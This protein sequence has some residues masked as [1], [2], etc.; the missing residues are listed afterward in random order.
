MNIS[1]IV[2]YYVEER[3]SLSTQQVDHYSFLIQTEL[4]VLWLPFYRAGGTLDALTHELEALN[5]RSCDKPGN[6]W[7]LA[8]EWIQ[9]LPQEHLW[10]Q[11]P[12]VRDF[13]QGLVDHFEHSLLLEK[14]IQKFG[15]TLPMIRTEVDSFTL[16]DWFLIWL[17]YEYPSLATFLFGLVKV[18]AIKSIL[19]KD[20]ACFV[21]YTPNFILWNL[22]KC[23][24]S[25]KD[26]WLVYQLGQ[27]VNIRGVQNSPVKCNKRMAHYFMNAPRG[28][29]L[30]GA[31]W[32]AIIK[33]FGGQEE[34]V[35]EFQNHFVGWQGRLPFLEVII[36]FF[37]RS[38]E[39]LELGEIPRLLG[40][41]QHRKDEKRTFCLKGQTLSS[42]RKRAEEWY[43][44]QEQLQKA[45]WEEAPYRNP[46][47][48]LKN[49][50]T[51][52]AGFD[53]PFEIVLEEACYHFVR[54]TGYRDL[55]EEGRE[56]KHCVGAYYKDCR[57]RGTEIWSLRKVKNDKPKRLV[58]IEVNKFDEIVQAKRKLN[59]E[60]AEWEWQLIE[61]WA[62]KQDLEIAVF[63]RL[64]R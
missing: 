9:C 14:L 11:V 26:R 43:A 46:T 15:L 56:M 41:L 52:R 49:Q 32:Y 37:A 2:D 60:P 64:S 42:L 57:K 63:H 38:K 36:R 34:W 29:D 12:K 16:I 1:R 62:K 28:L 3:Q 45:E 58:T 18:N 7:L 4:W 19:N 5:W 23:L 20:V 44:F 8:D 61:Q 13:I 39:Y 10:V 27:G 54:L 50:G 22:H 25:K 51:L 59:A 24:K 53:P 6:E 40:Y 21:L 17:I 55:I 31:V 33:G 48:L 35:A 47:Y 30:P